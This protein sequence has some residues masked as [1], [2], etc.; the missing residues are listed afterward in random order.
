MAQNYYK[1]FTDAS[2]LNNGNFQFLTDEIKVLLIT[3]QYVFNAS[4]ATIG[5]LVAGDEFAGAGY[6]A[7]GIPIAGKSLVGNALFGDNLSWPVITG[8]VSGAIM[9][10]A[11]GGA[12]MAHFDFG[13]TFNINEDELQI[14]WGEAGLF[15][16]TFN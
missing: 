6:T 14:N 15:V 3:N 13:Y 7:G 12:L 16:Q 8:D 2:I 1:G 11:S 9:Y 4:H 10:K 5:A